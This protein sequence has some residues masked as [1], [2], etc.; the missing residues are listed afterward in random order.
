MFVLPVWCVVATIGIWKRLQEEIGKGAFMMANNGDTT[1]SSGKSRVLAS[2][3]LVFETQS[4]LS[5]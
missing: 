4:M 2:A 3:S 1:I 5:E